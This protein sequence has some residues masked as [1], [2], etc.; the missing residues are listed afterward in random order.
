MY[1]CMYVILHIRTYIYSHTFHLP[2][3]AISNTTPPPPLALL[4]PLLSSPPL[5]SLLLS[6]PLLT[7]TMPCQ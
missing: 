5:L 7:I 6:N 1:V 2:T 4:S 3:A